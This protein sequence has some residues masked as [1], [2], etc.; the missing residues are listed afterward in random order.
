MGQDL[1]WAE[2]RTFD[3]EIKLSTNP[4]IFFY[5]VIRSF[6]QEVSSSACLGLQLSARAQYWKNQINLL[7]P[8]GLAGS[9]A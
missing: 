1:D 6:S 8:A 5:N 3:I 9:W 2:V 7:Q 4:I